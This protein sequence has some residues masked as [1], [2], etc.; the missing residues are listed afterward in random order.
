MRSG[1]RLLSMA[2]NNQLCSI[3]TPCRVAELKEV[4]GQIGQL[5]AQLL[6]SEQEMHLMRSKLEEEKTERE[7]AQ[8]Q[9]CWINLGSFLD[10]TFS[11]AAR[12]YFITIIIINRSRSS[13]STV[14]L[15]EFGRM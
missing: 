14:Y 10:P 12:I 6:R 5:R 2:I 4:G 3:C 15:F 13:A 8:K 9:V 7:K 1:I 11:Q